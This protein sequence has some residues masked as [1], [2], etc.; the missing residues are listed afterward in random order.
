MQTVVPTDED[1]KPM[2]AKR[3]HHAWCTLI[4]V[5]VCLLTLG[6]ARV[7]LSLRDSFGVCEC[8]GV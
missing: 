6:M 7:R 1:G 2:E 5:V 3:N 8:E 4:S